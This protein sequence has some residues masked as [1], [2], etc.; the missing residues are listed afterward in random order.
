MAKFFKMIE[1][2]GLRSYNTLFVCDDETP[3]P[4][5]EEIVKEMGWNSYCANDPVK[6]VSRLNWFI[7]LMIDIGRY[8]FS[9]YADELCE[10]APETD[11][12]H[13]WHWWYG[14]EEGEG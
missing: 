3:I 4:T 14:T 1:R 11:G 6:R 8:V 2:E 12:I 13:F 7:S 5:A 10:Y 9:R